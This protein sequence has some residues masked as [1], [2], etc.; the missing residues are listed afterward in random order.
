MFVETN[1]VGGSL[2]ISDLKESDLS[3][4]ASLLMTEDREMDFVVDAHA[5]LIPLIRT[6]LKVND[7]DE[8][9]ALS[10]AICEAATEYLKP[11]IQKLLTSAHTEAVMNFIFENNVQTS[12]CTE[13]GERLYHFQP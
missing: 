1:G 10:N 3:T 6:A 9:E 4:L 7:K 8:K 11:E 13:T 5:I 12:S 2:C